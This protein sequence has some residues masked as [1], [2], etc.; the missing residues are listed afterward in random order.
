[1]DH[2][3]PFLSLI[4]HDVAPTGDDLALCAG[5]ERGDWRR[6]Q[7]ADHVMQWIPEF[8]LS[9][10]ELMEISHFNAVEMTT[11]AARLIYQS[12]KY[13]NRGEFGELLLHIAIR[14]VYKTIPAVSKIFY[15]SAI[16]KT[17]EGFDAVHVIDNNNDLE[18]WI[19]ETKFYN[20]VD[21]AIRDVCKEIIDHLR[22]DYLRNE[23]I[24]I[25]NKIEDEWPHA[26]KLSKLLDS[27]VSLDTV[28]S[29]ACI[30][31]LMTYDSSVVKTTKVCDKNYLQDIRQELDDAWKKMR[32]KLTEQYDKAYSSSLPITVHVILIP[33][34]EK[35]EFIS[36]LDTRL[37]AKQI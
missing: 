14:Q 8:A 24:L 33:L 10:S 16:N 20:D 11:K 23:F 30:P 5:F 37:K 31:V 32:A 34:K 25:K 28:F 27:N 22:T 26:D 2:P 12:K 21:R 13:G 15:K 1:M 29:R 35:K 7:F 18:L 36:A 3:P 9:H 6:D 4:F 19:G 17:V